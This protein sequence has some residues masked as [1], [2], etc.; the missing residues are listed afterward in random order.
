MERLRTEI[1]SLKED[2]KGV[3]VNFQTGFS[4]NLFSGK[5]SDEV[6]QLMRQFFTGLTTKSE[7][8]KRLESVRE[9][10]IVQTVLAVLIDDGFI[11]TSDTSDIF[12]VEYKPSKASKKLSGNIDAEMQNFVKRTKL[13]TMLA[14]I[15]EDALLL[16]EYHLRIVQKKGVGIVELIDDIDAADILPIYKNHTPIF[17]LVSKS[18]GKENFYAHQNVIKVEADQVASFVLSKKR[19]RLR[20]DSP[21]QGKR[22]VAEHVRMGRSAIYPILG[23]LQQ[24][25]LAE[26]S[27]KVSS[28]KEMVMPN[29]VSVG[30]PA[31][32]SPADLKAITTSYENSINSMLNDAF[33]AMGD[34]P[35]NFEEV[36]SRLSASGVRVLPNFADSKGSINQIDLGTTVSRQQKDEGEDSVRNKIARALHIPSHY[37]NPQENPETRMTDLKMFSRYTRKLLSMQEGVATTIKRL[38][39]QHFLVK[40]GTV[41]SEEDIKVSFKSLVDMDLLDKMEFTVASVQVM[42]D[43]LNMVGNIQRSP[44]MGLEFNSDAVRDIM[45]Q[46]LAPLKSEK[47][48]LRLVPKSQG[49]DQ[50]AQNV[51]QYGGGGGGGG[52]APSPAG[53]PSGGQ[54][55]LDNGEE[56]PEDNP[57]DDEEDEY[58]FAPPEEDDDE[59]EDNMPPKKAKK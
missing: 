15:I 30:V 20:V 41:I 9:M 6:S 14:E 11:N 54:P 1:A 52:Y 56:D 27:A 8:I 59:D 33:R 29:I 21:F 3:A 55:N 13:S 23:R 37:I 58:G 46:F 47:N 36:I 18:G 26:I 42:Q 51:D 44:E 57:E 34:D 4:H 40:D 53:R 25:Q 43:F 7:H 32:T 5:S 38:V 17:Y 31:N 39:A 24:L 35:E 48:L 49:V 10:E 22:N 12:K 16:G 45:I 28:L 50:M 19:T 2:L